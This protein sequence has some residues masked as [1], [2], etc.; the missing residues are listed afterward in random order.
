MARPMHEHPC[1]QILTGKVENVGI[2]VPGATVL[3]CDVLAVR[4]RS[5]IN[6]SQAVGIDLR[7]LATSPLLKTRSQHTFG[8]HQVAVVVMN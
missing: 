3:Q 6:D 4:E 2:D 5:R 8:K 7:F 1:L